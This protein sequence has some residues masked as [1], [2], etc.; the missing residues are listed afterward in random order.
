F[1][2]GTPG[3]EQYIYRDRVYALPTLKQPTL[4]IDY[5]D[6]ESLIL[7]P[8][9]GKETEHLA[10]FVIKSPT[11]AIEAFEEAARQIIRE[12]EPDFDVSQVRVRFKNLPVEIEIPDIRVEHVGKLVSTI[13][14][15]NMIET[16]SSII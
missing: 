13:G 15:I 5:F 16:K 11:A 10:E 1:K 3:K 6:I 9:I 14:I 2:K 7:N 8:V 4:V 12:R